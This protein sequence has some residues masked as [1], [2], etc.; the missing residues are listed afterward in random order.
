MSALQ[1]S[2]ASSPLRQGLQAPMA[3]RAFPEIRTDVLGV[4]NE[5]SVRF[6]TGLCREYGRLTGKF[7]LGLSIDDGGFTSI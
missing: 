3:A 2:P 4:S 1:A 5:L 7:Y 6:T